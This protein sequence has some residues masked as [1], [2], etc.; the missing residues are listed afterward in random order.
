MLKK[1]PA[2][3]SFFKELNMNLGLKL[4]LFK[5]AEFLDRRI[6]HLVLDDKI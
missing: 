3:K 2:F 5:R 1:V 6:S 4:P